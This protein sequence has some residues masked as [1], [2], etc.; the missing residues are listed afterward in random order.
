MGEEAD[1]ILYS[2]GLSDDD[3]KKYNTVSNKSEAHFA[4]RRKYL[5][6][7]KFNMRRQQEG[8]PVDS[9]ITLLY[10]LAEHCNYH[11]LHD[12]MIQD[13]IVVG[14]RDSNLSE[15]LQIDPELSLDK[16]ITMTRWTEA[17]REQQGVVRGETDNTCTKIEAVEHS[18][19]NKSY[20]LRS[21]SA[22]FQSSQQERLR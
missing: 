22:R 12:A 3:R 20:E 10:R 5:R 7:K 21:K 11:D 8:E 4:K 9:F 1:G 14:L 16:A 18:Y 2:F 13:R 15:W 6:T 19:F 17:V